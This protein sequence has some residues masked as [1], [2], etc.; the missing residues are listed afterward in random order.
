MFTKKKL[1]L[2]FILLCSLHLSYSQLTLGV[3]TGFGISSLEGESFEL[4]SMKKTNFTLGLTLEAPMYE[5]DKVVMTKN[6]AIILETK[7]HSATV[8][9]YSGYYN[10]SGKVV[11]NINYVV[12][13]AFVKSIFEGRR[14][15]FFIDAGWYIGGALNANTIIKGD[16]AKEMADRGNA[17][18]Y[19]LNIGKDEELDD[20][21]RFDFGFLVGVG[22]Q[23]EEFVIG[24]RM[25]KGTINLNPDDEGDSYQ[26]HSLQLLVAYDFY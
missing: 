9:N 11:S 25:M 18:R 24:L 23:Y 5:W 12:V 13:P 1:A 4:S 19:K 14:Y 7:G 16:L 6:T 20:I 15:D 17:T 21:L 8:D 2:L 22:I 10:T 26:N 3:Q